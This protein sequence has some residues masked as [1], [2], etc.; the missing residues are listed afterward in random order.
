MT[1]VPASVR[2]HPPRLRSRAGRRDAD[3]A[4]VYERHHQAL[5]RYCRS[6]LHD[7]HDAQDALQN[8]MTKA[9][10]ALQDEQRDFELR[11]WLF[12]IAHNEAITLLRQRRG[13]S[14]LDDATP[15]RA[16]SRTGSAEREELRLLRTDLATLPERQRAALVLRELNGLSHAEIGAVLDLSPPVSSRRCSTRAPRLSDSRDGRALACEEVRR[17]LSDGDGRVLRGATVRAHL[18]TCAPCRGFRAELSRVPRRCGCWRRRCPSP[19]RPGWRRRCSAGP[20]SS[21]SPAWRSRAAEARSPPSSS[22]TRVTRVSEPPQSTPARASAVVTATPPAAT[23]TLPALAHA[24]P[25]ATAEADAAPARPR[26]AHGPRAVGSPAPRGATHRKTAP[27]TSAP[28]AA[29]GSTTA[30][31]FARG[32]PGPQREHRRRD[33]RGTVRELPP[34]KPVEGRGRSGS[35]PGHADAK[36]GNSGTAR[37]HSDTAPGNS[38]NAP[39]HAG[40][41]PGNS[42]NAPGHPGGTPATAR[43]PPG[44]PAGRRARAR[45]LPGTPVRRPARARAPPGSPPTRRARARTLPGRPPTLRVRA[46]R[47]RAKAPRL[48]AS[49]RSPTSRPSD[50]HRPQV[51]GRA[52]ARG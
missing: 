10:A 6:I 8:A 28:H 4:A 5:Y 50:H 7:D 23:V 33:G 52:V 17:T 24:T 9:F 42:E 20:R 19:A 45:T 12:R 26:G 31:A 32:E 34:D 21:C 35:A 49:P 39:G 37:G 47:L 11:P 22:S 41:T 40:G 16:S 46:L 13:T 30:G 43:A 44:T 38:S 15:A 25:V 3:F 48:P 27:A 14:T 18:R 51:E 36:P 2:L 29:G 1:A